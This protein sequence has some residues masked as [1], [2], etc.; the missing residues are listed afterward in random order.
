MYGLASTFWVASLISM[1]VHLLRW[2][3]VIHGRPNQT[4]TRLVV[5]DLDFMS[6]RPNQALPQPLLFR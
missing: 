4:E 1:V 6:T 3:G 5:A 2:G